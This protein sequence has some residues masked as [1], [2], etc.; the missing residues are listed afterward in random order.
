M[1]WVLVVLGV[2]GMSFAA[3]LT[4]RTE[5][6]AATP[7]PR[8]AVIAMV[9][10]DKIAT[11]APSATPTA[12]P[13]APPTNVPTAKPTATPTTGPTATPTQPPLADGIYAT[14]GLVYEDSIGVTHVLGT[15]LNNTDQAIRFVEVTVNFYDSSGTLLDTDFTYANP[16]VIGPR[17]VGVFDS[18]TIDRPAAASQISV[19]VTDSSPAD[20]PPFWSTD[21]TVTQTNYFVDSI[22]FGHVI[23]TVTNH[24]ATSLDYVDIYAAYF[25]PGT[26]QVVNVDFTFSKPST[27]APGQ[28]GTFELLLSPHDGFDPHTVNSLQHLFFPDADRP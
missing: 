26:D 18:I 6:N 27:L 7:L 1:K 21:L 4:L 20:D 24:T 8:Q 5:S 16:D 14:R 22:D 9:A 2:A 17:S 11:T 10:A 12:L 3:L 28:T 19:Q 25:L 23:G 13:T 15:V